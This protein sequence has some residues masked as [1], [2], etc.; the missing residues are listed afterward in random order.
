M[1]DY[2]SMPFADNEVDGI[3]NL[4]L[5]HVGDA[6]LTLLTRTWLCKTGKATAGGLHKAA[7]QYVSATAQARA[8]SALLPHL[9]VEEAAVYRRG[10]NARTGSLPQSASPSEYHAATG[11]EALFG[12][13]HLKGRRDRVSALFAMMMEE[14]DGV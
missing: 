13:L 6:V 7:V 5:A 4:G 1:T 11:L 10:R 12:Y 8:A 2:Y 14:K 3:S 9:D